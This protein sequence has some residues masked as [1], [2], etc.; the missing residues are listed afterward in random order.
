MT[1]VRKGRCDWVGHPRVEEYLIDTPPP[2]LSSFVDMMVML[3]LSMGPFFSLF[4]FYRIWI[5]MC[6]VR[7]SRDLDWGDTTTDLN[8]VAFVVLVVVVLITNG[9]PAAWCSCGWM[10][11]S[12]LLRYRTPRPCD[13]P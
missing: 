1:T 6:D 3:Y 10:A 4:R 13:D 9:R 11:L 7:V 12:P 8:Y 2:P 5:G